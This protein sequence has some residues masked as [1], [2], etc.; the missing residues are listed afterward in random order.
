M[1]MLELFW[2]FINFFP[3]QYQSQFIF[4]KFQVNLLT[5]AYLQEQQYFFEFLALYFILMD[6]A[7]HS[8]A[9]DS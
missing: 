5:E 9:L 1:L 3:S 2:K 7:D 8:N 4:S 6:K